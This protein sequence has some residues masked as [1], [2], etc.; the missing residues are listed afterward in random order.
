M[1]LRGAALQLLG[2]GAQPVP[3]RGR[4]DLRLGRALEI[5]E[6]GEGLGDRAAGDDDAVAGQHQG[7]GIA[8]LR[9]DPVALVTVQRQAAIGLVIGDAAVEDQRVLL[10]HLEAAVLAQGE[11]RGIGHVGVQH[12]DR[13]RRFQ[14]DARMDEERGRL[15]RVLALEHGAGGVAQ[16]QRGGGDLR[17]VPAIR[18]DQEPVAAHHSVRVRHGQ[19]EMVAHP[20]VQA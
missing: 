16:D 17:P 6:V 10:A 4:Q 20:L 5:V 8:E 12:A 11:R 13:L 14:M 1:L 2:D 7:A 3:A 15:D 9:R 19:R 18:V